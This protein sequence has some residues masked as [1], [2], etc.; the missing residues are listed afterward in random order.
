MLV[1]EKKLL[2]FIRVVESDEKSFASVD[3][4]ATPSKPISG[5]RH[6]FSLL[7]TFPA[8]RTISF[9]VST[10]CFTA[11]RLTDT[12]FPS[13]DLPPSSSTRLLILSCSI[14]SIAGMA[15]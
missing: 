15:L 14:R 4:Y 8:A 10:A 9:A 11:S 6:F 5:R 12:I 2:E 3:C 13:T 1:V 7:H